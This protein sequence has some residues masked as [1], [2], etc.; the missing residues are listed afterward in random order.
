MRIV[1]Y[2]VNI[3]IG[4]V[5]YNLTYHKA[6][7]IACLIIG[8]FLQ[9]NDTIVMV[10]IILSHSAF[11]CVLGFGIKYPDYFKYTSFGNLWY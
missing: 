2:I 11:D 3:R 6:T 7:C 1:G 8:Y 5:A 9:S 10:I 4:V